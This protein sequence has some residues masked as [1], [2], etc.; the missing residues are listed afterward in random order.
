LAVIPDA[1]LRIVDAC[2]RCRNVST[3][4][5]TN[6]NVMSGAVRDHRRNKN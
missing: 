1:Q 6:P 2:G 4:P 3:T 5:V